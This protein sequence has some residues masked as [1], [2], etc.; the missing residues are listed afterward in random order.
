MRNRANI[1]AEQVRA[2]LEYNE[3]TGE[4]RWKP[5]TPDMFEDGNQGRAANAKAWNTKLSG[6]IAGVRCGNG[7]T[8]I[9]IK[10][11]KYYAHRLAILMVTGKWPNHQVDHVNGD[12]SDNRLCNI[13]EASQYENM[14]NCT[15]STNNSG[16]T[17]VSFK[18]KTIRWIAQIN[19]YG[20]QIYLGS[21][22]TKEE[23]A[24]AY[25]KAKSKLHTFNPTPREVRDEQ[26]A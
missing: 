13:R 2:M 12:R 26:A 7:Y 11:K 14:Q 8:A 23:A 3:N 16:Y 20:K 25:L 5:R 9:A 1:T 18:A 6:K 24:K 15:F 21:F 4:F 19:A 10:N 22:K 17:G